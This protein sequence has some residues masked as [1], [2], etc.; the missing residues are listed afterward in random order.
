MP[1]ISPDIT[2]IIGNTPMLRLSRLGTGLEAQLLAK[3]E[4]QNPLGSVKDRIGL[5]MINA[6]EEQGL[7]NPTTTII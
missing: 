7:L 3:L 4:F 1:R 6:A 2:A 5:A